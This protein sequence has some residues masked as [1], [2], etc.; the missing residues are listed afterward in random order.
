[1]RNS[2]NN[3]EFFSVFPILIEEVV[4]VSQRHHTPNNRIFEQEED[5]VGISLAMENG[6][7]LRSY[8]LYTVNWVNAVLV[9]APHIHC[10]VCAHSHQFCHFC[11]FPCVN[12]YGI[13]LFVVFRVVEYFEV[14]GHFLDGVRLD[15][16]GLWAFCDG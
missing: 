1:M 13:Y 5:V 10:L 3:F 11:L 16:D 6:H 7:K 2:L 14:G 9:D 8:K 12:V 15:Y 4:L